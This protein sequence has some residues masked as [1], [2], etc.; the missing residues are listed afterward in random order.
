MRRRG[1]T[2]VTEGEAEM[3][4][5]LEHVY[6]QIRG[7]LQ[8]GEGDPVPSAGPGTRQVLCEQTVPSETNEQRESFCGYSLWVLS[9]PTNYSKNVAVLP[10]SGTA[11]P[12]RTA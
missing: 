1:G 5:R 8:E 12:L 11:G 10:L 3:S 6:A 4:G 2:E 7:A 9:Q